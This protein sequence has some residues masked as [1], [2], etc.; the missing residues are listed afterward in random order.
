MVMSEPFIVE[1][2]GEPV[3]IVLAEERDF[4]FPV[5]LQ[6]IV[7]PAAGQFKGKICCPTDR[8]AAIEG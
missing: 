5:R 1:V 2:W 6:G 8:V 3:G 4:R 7:G